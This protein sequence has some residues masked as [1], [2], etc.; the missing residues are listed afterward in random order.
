MSRHRKLQKKICGKN[1]KIDAKTPKGKKVDCLKEDQVIEVELSERFCPAADRLGEFPD[2]EKHLRVPN[3]ALDRAKDHLE[4][5]CINSDNILLNNL[6][7]T[8]PHIIRRGRNTF[9]KVGIV[10]IGLGLLW[11]QKWIK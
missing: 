11:I 7:G 8:N 4:N 10:L 6:S 1:G 2:R 5:K 9:T 3:N